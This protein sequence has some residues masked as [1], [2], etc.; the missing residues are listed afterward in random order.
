M[1]SF[2]LDTPDPPSALQTI[3]ENAKKKSSSFTNTCVKASASVSLHHNA[4][5]WSPQSPV[6]P[7]KRWS[8]NRSNSLEIEDWYDRSLQGSNSSSPRL[9]PVPS[10]SRGSP[11][12]FPTNLY[13]VMFTFKP[14]EKD[15]LEIKAGWRVSTLETSD[16]DWWKGKCNGRVGFFP[17]SYVERINYGE[18]V[19]QVTH[20]L[21]LNEGD[22][23][24]K[25]HRDQIVIQMSEEDQHGMV[26]IRTRDKRT[27]CPMKYLTEV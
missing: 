16:P 27:M 23:G 12:Q 20:S 15:D 14:R 7:R 5:T 4:C 1:K 24:V 8:N 13:V 25:L 11:R 22:N 3:D 26:L 10:G 9:S 19:C 6:H 18:K 21:Q 2:S 17:A